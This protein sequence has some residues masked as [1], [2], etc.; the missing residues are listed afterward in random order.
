M[1]RILIFLF[2]FMFILCHPATAQ[3]PSKVFLPDILV[4]KSLEVGDRYFY[5][6]HQ[7]SI[8]M[9]PLQNPQAPIKTLGR[10]GEGPKEFRGHPSVQILK[11][12]L[13]VASVFKY[14]YFTGSGDFISEHKAPF[15][16]KSL[17]KLGKNHMLTYYGESEKKVLN[18]MAVFDE[19]FKPLKTINSF[20]MSNV[21]NDLDLTSAKTLTRCYDGKLFYLD[22][23]HDFSIKVF[24][25]NGNALY[26]INRRYEKIRVTEEQRK[27]LEEDFWN[28]PAVKK[29]RKHLK[30]LRLTCSEHCPA[31]RNFLVADGKIYVKTSAVKPGKEEFVILDLKGNLLNR[32]FLPATAYRL[33]AVR[34]GIFYFLAENDE[35]DW[36]FHRVPIPDAKDDD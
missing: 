16:L 14:I 24:D 34:S 36:E 17:K 33:F 5:I 6:S 28:R 29:Y 27:R 1:F 9:Y 12:R 25:Q 21:P 31:I 13:L 2:V 20:D 10:E 35:E 23:S 32:V 11:D 18:K 30:K 7:K 8:L 19:K 3:T 15:L 26:E 4:P 22:G